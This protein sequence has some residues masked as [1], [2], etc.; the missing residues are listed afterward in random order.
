MLR[1][2]PSDHTVATTAASIAVSSQR[3]DMAPTSRF[4]RTMPRS[5]RY[6]AESKILP[7]QEAFPEQMV[8]ARGEEL[9]AERRELRAEAES[10]AL[11]AVESESRELRAVES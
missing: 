8:R 3:S 10:Q 1:E 2:G 9:R 6:T 4:E 11:R 5:C 7:E